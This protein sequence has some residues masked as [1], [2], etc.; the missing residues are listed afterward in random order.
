[1]KPLAASQQVKFEPGPYLI[2]CILVGVGALLA[3]LGFALGSLHS[4]NQGIRWVRSWEQDPGDLA[5]MKWEKMKVAS[6]A[7]ADAWK[8]SAPA[9]SASASVADDGGQ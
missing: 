2:G 1:M 6:A 8:T 3:F 5:K 7:S 4:I 9:S